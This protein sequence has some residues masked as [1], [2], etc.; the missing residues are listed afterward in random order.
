MKKR[1]VFYAA[2]VAFALA[3]GFSSC[4]SS[5][6]DPI[7]L[8]DEIKPT[9]TD[10]ILAMPLEVLDQPKDNDEEAVISVTD[11]PI[12]KIVL[13]KGKKAMIY[14]KT[15]RAINDN[16]ILC[17][18]KVVGSDIVI[19][20]L[21]YTIKIGTGAVA[22]VMIGNDEYPAKK[23]A[24][25]APAGNEVSLC[26]AWGNAKYRAAVKFDQLPVYGAKADEQVEVASIID[27]N[28]KIL[29]KLISDQG[30]K[31]EGFNLLRNNLTGVNF[32][33]NGTVYFT[34]AD[35][36]IE[37]STWKWIDKTKGKL[38]TTLDG[39]NVN[40]EL[41]FKKGQ[42]NT[43]YFVIDANLAHIGGLGVHTLSGQLICTMTD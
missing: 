8:P 37:E 10:E 29:N 42:P 23:Q 19:E 36:K 20:A 21:G 40:V 12:E 5:E 35:G 6:D 34:Y 11:A 30:L 43:A 13:A 9:I 17:S 4:S 1:N 22:S 14:K 3:L 31:N 24:I 25:D 33:N 27:L 16:V 15:T 2:F 39:V 7:V 26:R 41:R 32:V 18:Y 28:K 38:N